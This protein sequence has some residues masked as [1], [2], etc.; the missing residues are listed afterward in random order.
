[1]IGFCWAVGA[2]LGLA[3]RPQTPTTLPSLAGSQNTPS[4]NQKQVAEKPVTVEIPAINYYSR[5]GESKIEFSPTALM[6]SARGQG[7]VKILKDGSVSVEVR[8]S[9]LESATKFGNQFLTYVLWGSVPKGPTLNIGEVTLTGDGGRVFAT[10]VL[11]T[12][13]M[14]VTA[15]PYAVVTE[16]SS[17]V[18]LKA[19][20]PT[21]D[22][23]QTG[24][25]QVALLDNAYTP[26]GYNY[27]PLDTASGYAPELIQAINA[28]RIAKALDAEKYAPVQ[29]HQAEDL[30]HYLTGS[31]KLEKKPSKEL[32]GV[33]KSVAQSYEK[34]RAMSVRKQSRK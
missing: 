32:L 19:G 11:R 13:A 3:V 21:S 20:L 6:P 8:F 10:T 30:Y 16:P 2:F 27:E 14:M 17:F 24:I 5:G 4:Y 15:E 33:A 9:G 25:A 18:I 12:F 22:T 7:Q 28:R 31:A 23:S 34:A 26:P 29:F 1:M